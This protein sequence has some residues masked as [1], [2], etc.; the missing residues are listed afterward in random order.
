MTTMVL[1]R[2]QLSSVWLPMLMLML[3]DKLCRKY[4]I[5]YLSNS[6]SYCPILHTIVF[7]CPIVSAHL[8]VPHCSEEEKENLKL[9]RIVARML[10]DDV[11]WCFVIDADCIDFRIKC[12]EGFSDQYIIV[13]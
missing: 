6:I 11:E 2:P 10:Q 12:N 7:L 5:F 13:L 9:V 1:Q 8:L 4:V 3:T